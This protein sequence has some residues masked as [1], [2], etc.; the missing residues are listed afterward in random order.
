M[1]PTTNPARR[2]SPRPRRH[3]RPGLSRAPCTTCSRMPTATRRASS[4]R[5]RGLAAPFDLPTSSAAGLGM[6]DAA[7][8]ARASWSGARTLR[9]RRDRH[10][11][12]AARPGDRRSPAARRTYKRVRDDVPA[13]ATAPTGYSVGAAA[14][15]ATV[16]GA[17]GGRPAAM[18]A[19]APTSRPRRRPGDAHDD[20]A[21]PCRRGST[22]RTAGETEG[23]EQAAR[24][25]PA[26]GA[27]RT[28]TR[29]SP[30]RRGCA[31]WPW[32]PPASIAAALAA[33]ARLVR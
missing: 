8:A 1:E 24:S 23:M 19:R 12:V 25:S 18:T 33:R 6:Y 32:T 20:A 14:C 16:A 11:G 9:R 2:L 10:R 13:L 5:V 22:R 30:A 7:P 21:R 15:A 31:C 28:S 4:R 27:P 29:S 26:L 17:D 3:S